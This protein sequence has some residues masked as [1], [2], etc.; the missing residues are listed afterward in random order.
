MK[1]FD[2]AIAPFVQKVVSEENDQV[3]KYVVTTK[4]RHNSINLET[5]ARDQ[6]G[7]LG[8]RTKQRKLITP[9][10]TFKTIDAAAEAEGTTRNAIYA[11]MKRC[12]DKYYDEIPTD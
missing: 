1:D 4:I 6:E 5:I 10:G 12:P 9:L 8:P 3:V 2:K 11:K 7:K